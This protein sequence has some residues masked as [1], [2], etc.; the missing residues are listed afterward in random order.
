MYLV[1]L[2][3]RKCYF[4]SSPATCMVSFTFPT[5]NKFV[6]GSFCACAGIPEY[7]LLSLHSLCFICFDFLLACISILVSEPKMSSTTFLPQPLH[8]LFLSY[9]LLLLL[10][11]FIDLHSHCLL[12]HFLLLPHLSLLVSHRTLIPLLQYV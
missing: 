9:L 4:V 2:S 8:I 5:L 10:L 7:S 12:I 11:P 6:S 1:V 3:C